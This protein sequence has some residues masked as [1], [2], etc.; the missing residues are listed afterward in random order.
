[1]SKK[2]FTLI[3]LLVVIA[4][5]AVLAGMLLPSLNKSKET[6]RTILCAN[7]QKSLGLFC[8][9]YTDNSNGGLIARNFKFRQGAQ[10]Q[11]EYFEFQMILCPEAQM[12]CQMNTSELSAAINTSLDHGVRTANFKRLFGQYFECPSQPVRSYK[13]QPY[14]HYAFWPSTCGYGYN[15]Y[16]ADET[17]GVMN[18]NRLKGISP[19]RIPRLADIWKA[20]IVTG[21]PSSSKLWFC[22]LPVSS[23]TD[24][25]Q[26]WG[27]NGAHEKGSNFLWMDGHVSRETGRPSGYDTDPWRKK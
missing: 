6:A 25:Y 4:I 26:P 7:Q 12:P 1:M 14:T 23:E 17:W 9:F 15:F 20:Q 21:A 10:I 5:I 22:S 2:S 27:E 16:I 24:R 3:E 11:A 19:S 18:V 8:Q 13:N